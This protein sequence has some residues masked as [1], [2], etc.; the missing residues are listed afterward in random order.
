VKKNFV[1]GLTIVALV[2]GFAGM[3]GATNL[4]VNGSFEN[5][6]YYTPQWQRLFAGSTD[7]S[8]WTIGGVGV[9]WHVATDNPALNPA[10][11]GHEFGPAQDGSLVI[12]FHLDGDFNGT[13]SQ[14]FATSA[15]TTYQVSFY[16]AG[17]DWFS[18][19]RDIQVDVNGDTKIFSQAA[20]DPLNL[21]WGIKEFQF[22]ATGSTATLTFSCTDV[23]G[24]WGPL[25]DNVSVEVVPAPATM[26]LFGTG[27]AGLIASRLRRKK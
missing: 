4:I 5:G 24:Y 25:L 11:T 10:L 23:D 7:L 3:A 6:N 16:L 15:G 12:D 21:V 8:N 17:V 20:S 14:T 19:P 27:L 9:D 22:N 1:A 2:I 13:I 18:N 26:L